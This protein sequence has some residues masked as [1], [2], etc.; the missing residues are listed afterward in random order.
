[1]D[2]TEIILLGVGILL[3]FKLVKELAYIKMYAF[4][5]RLKAEGKLIPEN[6]PNGVA[7]KAEADLKKNASKYF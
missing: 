1:M 3:L 4:I 7:D 2:K 5:I 6:D